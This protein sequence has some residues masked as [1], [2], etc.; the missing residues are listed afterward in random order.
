MSLKFTG[1]QVYHGRGPQPTTEG[2]AVTSVH[3]S[4]SALESGVGDH[5]SKHLEAISTIERFCEIRANDC[6]L[7]PAVHHFCR[8]K[9]APA[10]DVK[11]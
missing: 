10:T 11:R 3:L 7:G 4:H 8:M 2:V 5:A 9:S 6:P 1:L